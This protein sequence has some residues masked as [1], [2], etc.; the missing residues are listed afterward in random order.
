MAFTPAG[1]H[2][3]GIRA[4]GARP[5]LSVR[6]PQR[7]SSRRSHV[8]CAHVLVLN[9]EK[10]GHAF[11]GGYLSSALLAAGHTVKVQQAGKEG[12]PACSQY[13]SLASAHADSFSVS[14]GPPD[15]SS[16]AGSF[17]AVYDNFAKDSAT[18]AASLAA[19]AAGAEVFYV[20]SAGA[21]AEP[22]MGLAP[23]L[24]GDSASGG[25]ITAEDALRTA[26][27]CA[28]AFRPIYIF[29]RHSAKRAYL[30]FF[31]DRAVR[32][33]PIYIPG[34]GSEL[35]SLTEVRDVAGM[36]ASALG[37]GLK[38][39]TFN[40][41][42][43]RG[44]T[45][46]GVA[47]LV[48]SVVGRDCIVR[49]YDPAWAEKHVEG[50]AVKKVFPFRVRH[51]FAD[52]KEAR[53]KLGWEPQFSGSVAQLLGSIGE[54]YEEYK[55]LGLHEKEMSFPMDDAISKAIADEQGNM[56]LR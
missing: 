53:N 10:G 34:T 9:C 15:A 38:D 45:F 54:A 18:A 26:G 1:W 11:L 28:A 6:R 31:F 23:S 44:V 27:V 7:R 12:G 13:D 41:T 25:T 35:T 16:A 48:A 37:K 49:H 42:S 2:G 24:V 4:A 36:M 14:Y 20:S 3:G 17:D 33:R 29:G 22:P 51:F 19:G 8:R 30:D 55:E 32:A 39:E 43:T 56:H 47:Q 46:D 52:P 21:Y 5:S 40:A 50:F